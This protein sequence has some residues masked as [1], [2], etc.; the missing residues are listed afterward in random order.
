MTEMR[1]KRLSQWVDSKGLDCLI[2]EHPSD[3]FYLTGLWFSVGRFVATKEGGAL[4][5]DGRYYEIA[6]KKISF[7]K[8][9]SAEKEEWCGVLD[10]AKKVGFD[11]AFLTVDAY[12]TL[13]ET[14]LG[15]QWI[16]ILNPLKEAR[17]CKDPAE[18]AA[19]KR[20]AKLTWDG[21]QRV[22]GLLKEG[23]TEIEIA[24]EFEFYCRHHGASAM[25]FEP[26]VAFG[27]NSAYPHYRPGPVRLKQNQAVLLDFGAVVDNYRGDMTRVFFFGKPDPKLERFYQLIREAHDAAFAAVRPGIR[28]GV[29]DEIVRAILSKEGVESLFIHKLGHGVGIDVHEYPRLHFSGADRDLLLRPGMVFTIEPG[30]YLPGVGGVRYENTIAVTKEGAENFYALL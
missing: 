10:G 8:V 21:Y 25:S 1:M 20:A 18:I 12:E 13:K 14:L 26:I 27:E 19:L 6:K 5:V 9:L 23:V 7:C 30:L 2:V 16:P 17:N 4:L 28:L 3:L 24:L 15:K 11:S 29:L 22:L